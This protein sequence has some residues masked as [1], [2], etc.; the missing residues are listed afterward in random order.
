[1]DSHPSELSYE[2]LLRENKRLKQH[3][4]LLEQQVEALG[5]DNRYFTG[6]AIGRS[7]NQKDALE[8]YC[9][10]KNEGAAGHRRRVQEREQQKK[11]SAT[12]AA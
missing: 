1:M 8:Y 5:D 6:L 10:P 2:E 9:D 12:K 11:A 7:P 3:V 4:D